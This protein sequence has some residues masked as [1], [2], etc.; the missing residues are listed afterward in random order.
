MIISQDTHPTKNLYY[1]GFLLIEIIQKYNNNISS[2]DLFSELNQKQEISYSMFILSLDWLFLLELV[3][4]DHD[5]I[6][7]CF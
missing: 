6:K 1:I 4:I 2:H 5:D 3:N 7:I